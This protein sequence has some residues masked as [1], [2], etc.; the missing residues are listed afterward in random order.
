MLHPAI[1]LT[2]LLQGQVVITDFDFGSGSEIAVA[3]SSNSVQVVDLEDGRLARRFGAHGDLVGSLRFSPDGRLLVTA[4]NDGKARIFDTRTTVELAS[5]DAYA[6]IDSRPYA[7]VS[8]DGKRLLTCGRRKEATLWNVAEKK[9]IATLG[10]D[11]G[12]VEF[13]SW[14]H[15]STRIVTAT[16]GR[17]GR[18]WDGVTGKPLSDPVRLPTSDVECLALSP[19]GWHLAVAC[20]D[21]RAR[22]VDLR[23]GKTVV[24]VSHKD[25]DLLNDTAVGSVAFSADGAHLLTATL[26]DVRSWNATTGAAEWQNFFGGGDGGWTGAQYTADAREVFVTQ[27]PKW[28]DAKTGA[29]KRQLSGSDFGY[30]D[31]SPD[32]RY[33]TKVVHG[34]RVAAGDIVLRDT[35]TLEER[36]GI[37]VGADGLAS[38]RKMPTKGESGR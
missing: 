20:K 34:E 30:Y 21:A 5:F 14:S 23:T 32:G 7:D 8:N 22:I 37:S 13:A 16:D 11:T 1:L 2:T 4:C 12:I 35:S 25:I 9:R 19:D 24:T 6:G 10:D 38:V 27:G 15:D 29:L 31:L 18:L 33:V 3:T 26:C 17:C 28:F 36:F